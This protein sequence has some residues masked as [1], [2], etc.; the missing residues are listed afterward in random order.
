MKHIDLWT[1]KL[2]DYGR[3]Y[4][5]LKDN[6]WVRIIKYPDRYRFETSDGTDLFFNTIN[7]AIDQIKIETL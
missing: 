6:N 2:T 1:K 4:I 7:E 3:L 5:T